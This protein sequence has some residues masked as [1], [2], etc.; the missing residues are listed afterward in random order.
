MKTLTVR[1][2]N[3]RAFKTFKFRDAETKDAVK[4]FDI[5]FKDEFKRFRVI[6]PKDWTSIDVAFLRDHF[7]TNT[8]TVVP[9]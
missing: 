8:I 4:V 3:T 6:L 1:K 9:S 5:R 7:P 2:S